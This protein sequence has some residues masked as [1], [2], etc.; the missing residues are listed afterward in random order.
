MTLEQPLTQVLTSFQS[1][2]ARRFSL[3]LHDTS[4][5]IQPLKEDNQ[6]ACMHLY[7]HAYDCAVVQ[8]LMSDSSSFGFNLPGSLSSSQQQTPSYFLLLP[9]D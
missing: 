4:F 5:R 1:R 9:E 7:L 3:K 8:S 2:L 6:H